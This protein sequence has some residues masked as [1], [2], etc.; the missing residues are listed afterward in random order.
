M[1]TGAT[2]FVPVAPHPKLNY[3]LTQAGMTR[4]K[5][6]E[7]FNPIKNKMLHIDTL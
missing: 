3:P 4:E 1:L 2:L 5:R 7:L 6:K